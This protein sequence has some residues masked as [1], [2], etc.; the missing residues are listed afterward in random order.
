MVLV[1]LASAAGLPTLPAGAQD[2]AEIESRRPPRTTDSDA[3]RRTTAERM[4]GRI[5]PERSRTPQQVVCR[6]FRRDCRDALRVAHCES[7]FRTDATN[8]QYLGLFQMGS[9]A[10]SLYGH[11][12]TAVVQ[13]RAAHRYFVDSGRDWSPWSCRP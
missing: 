13:A 9:T 6:V 8:G 10:R 1:S 4:R 5:A 12:A 3:G 2:G 11:G 7:R